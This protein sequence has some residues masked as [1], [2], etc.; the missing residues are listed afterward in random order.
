MI[1]V[2]VDNKR[3]GEVS[4]LSFEGRVAYRNPRYFDKTEKCDGVYV[5]G[6][7]PNI[8]Q[9][10]KGKIINPVSDLKKVIGQSTDYTI[11]ELRDMKPD[12]EN[13]ESF[14]EGDERKSVTQ[15]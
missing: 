15:I 4:S 10:Y 1:L 3:F 11:A 13:W 8:E 6:N 9:A 5:H 12:I 14:I 7:Y 2:Y